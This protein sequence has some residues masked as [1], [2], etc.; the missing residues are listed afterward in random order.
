MFGE[1]ISGL[2]GG[3]SSMF[4]ADASAKASERNTERQIEWEREKFA[5][6]TELANSAHQREVADLKSAGLN[7]ILSADSSGASTPTMDSITP[8]MPDTSGYTSAGKYLQ[9]IVTNIYANKVNM[10]TAKKTEEEAKTQT[11]QRAN[12]KAQKI[13]NLAQ[14]GLIDK[15]KAIKDIEKLQKKLDL[16]WSPYEKASKMFNQISM[17]I[18]SAVGMFNAGKFLKNLKRL[19]GMKNKIDFNTGEILDFTGL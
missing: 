3:A 4:G 10:A 12:L 5:K 11:E 18:I 14:V 13:L 9:D 16:D 1:I 6:E 19:P 8:Q 7:P 17:P 15:E 2:I